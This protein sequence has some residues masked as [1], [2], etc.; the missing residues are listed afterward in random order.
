MAGLGWS[1]AP[2]PTGS[3]KE[4]YECKCEGETFKKWLSE[5]F[6]CSA[7]PAG[8]TFVKGHYN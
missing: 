3:I 6:E 4:G 1:C 5:S 8:T 7:C 2:C